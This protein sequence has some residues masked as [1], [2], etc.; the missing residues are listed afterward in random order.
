M[1]STNNMCP[2]LR[3]L[4]LCF[5]IY[6]SS[7]IQHKCSQ[8]AAPRREFSHR[9]ENSSSFIELWYEEKWCK[10]NHLLS[11]ESSLCLIHVC[12]TKNTLCVETTK[13]KWRTTM[14]GLTWLEVI[15][16]CWVADKHTHTRTEEALLVKRQDIFCFQQLHNFS[17]HFKMIDNRNT[18]QFYYFC[19]KG[20]HSSSA[21]FHSC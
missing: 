8:D 12:V 16:V 15:H 1:F 3:W 20:L 18:S 17:Q 4:F 5:A 6:T 14:V 21:F 10:Q 9:P 19:S 7:Q 2:K 11:K 13:H